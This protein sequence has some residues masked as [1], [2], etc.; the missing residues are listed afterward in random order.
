MSRLSIR[1]YLVT[2]KRYLRQAIQDKGTASFVIGNE[3]ADLDSITCALVY[4]YIQSSSPQARRKNHVVIP[5]TN[6]PAADL[7]LR[8]ELTALLRHAGVKPDDLITLDDLGKLPMP[9]S[10]IDWTLVDHNALTGCLAQHYAPSVS[11]VID[12]HD[13]ESAVPSSAS[14]RII[15]KSGSCNSLVV[16]QLRSSWDDISSNSTSVG[17][18]N[19]Q[20]SDGVID[21]EAHT[22]TWDAQVAE[23]ALGSILIDTHC[24]GDESKVTEHDRKAVRYL[25]A[26]INA[27]NKYGKDYDRKVFFEEIN[28]A[29]SDLDALSLIDVLRKDYK[30]WTEGAK[31]VGVS[32]VVKP[33]SWLREKVE[34]NFTQTLID[35]AG[36]R[37]LQLLAIMT[38]F[39]SES[40]DFA[41]ELLLIALDSEGATKAAERFVE[42]AAS[43]LKIKQ[44]ELQSLSEKG[45]PPFMQLWHQ[46]NVAA[47][48]KKV[49]P[50]LREAMRTTLA[51]N[52]TPLS[53][54]I[55][56]RHKG[57]AFR[58]A[59]QPLRPLSLTIM[60][61]TPG[62]QGG[63]QQS[64]Q[65]WAYNDGRTSV[66][67]HHQQTTF[68]QSAVSTPAPIPSPYQILPPVAMPQM[69][70]AP[71]I[72]QQHQNLHSA[73]MQ[74]AAQIHASAA[75]GMFQS[76][77]HTLPAPTMLF[78]QQAHM[79]PPAQGI[80]PQAQIG[81]APSTPV[82]QVLSP[83]SP[84]AQMAAPYSSSQQRGVAQTQRLAGHEPGFVEEGEA[85][86]SGEE[87]SEDE[88]EEQSAQATQRAMEEQLRRIEDQ[89][90]SER[91]EREV[92]TTRERK[93][94]ET[95]DAQ[96]AKDRQDREAE[97]TRDRQTREAR[98]RE[99]RNR[100]DLEVA[101]LQS[102]LNAERE[103]KDR[104]LAMVQSTL[105][106]EREKKDL[107]LAMMQSKLDTERQEKL[108]QER[109]YSRQLAAFA[110]KASSPQPQP[111]YNIDLSPL[112]TVLAELSA[113]RLQTCDIA[114]L[115]ENTM[116]R[117]LQGVARSEDLAS[118]TSKVQKALNK[119]PAN[120][121]AAD[122]QKAVEKGIADVMK[123]A[124]KSRGRG[125]QAAIE[126]G[127]VPQSGSGQQQGGLSRLQ[128]EY[129]IEDITDDQPHNSTLEAS[130]RRALPAPEYPAY[131]QSATPVMSF[132]NSRPPPAPEYPA[133]PQSAAPLASSSKSQASADRA[134]VYGGNDNELARAQLMGAPSR[135]SPPL[136]EHALS[137]S[138]QSEAGSLGGKTRKP[139][140][141]NDGN[142]LAKVKRRCAAPSIAPSA[143]TENALAKFSPTEAGPSMSGL[144]NTR[145]P[146]RPRDHEAMSQVGGV[147][148]DPPP[149]TEMADSSQLSLRGGTRQVSTGPELPDDFPDNA[150][151]ITTYERARDTRATS[152]R[153]GTTDD[154]SVDRLKLKHDRQEDMALV[155]G[156]KK[157]SKK[158][159]KR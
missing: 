149:Y 134:L 103:Q 111:T 18:A 11:G 110:E 25:E 32:S 38:A 151:M 50:L 5:V 6:I 119:L 40:G 26:R 117:Q 109:K 44:S 84:Q 36:Q 91:K 7:S 116:A 34:G 70:P 96:A 75:Q 21:D 156:S 37:Q 82:P 48:R 90:A 33:I 138:E 121:S 133:Y 61:N 81:Y 66:Q 62:G 47:S 85:S 127:P 98:D 39:T 146:A 2:A 46:K 148:V 69:L 92:Q 143:L 65:Q 77:Q 56:S 14:P 131:A 135:D 118:S 141:S 122:V 63:Y 49:G 144:S 136:A 30:Q 27:S 35:F 129:T 120:A 147:D 54:S 108:D 24:L 29:K 43:E 142:A 12:H 57:R 19:A 130:Q 99:E 94:R 124:S 125:Q 154:R 150:S 16:N 115:V 152:A 10:K 73:A 114:A 72:F 86:S 155:K 128:V 60:S 93:D 78:Q 76:M 45:R 31:T 51:T 139:A 102:R 97:D 95:R 13:D 113:N 23:L 89:H 71:N 157:E 159:W 4:G 140:R 112:Q 132:S 158:F 17:A 153:S 137:L 145:S 74:Q 106:A 59:E 42:Q 80:Y 107:E 79:L 28:A 58:S 64:N 8:P 68:A 67:Y 123:K 104:D 101:S 15:E 3:S 22:T 52:S 9:L 20:S 126:A 1:T 88:A 105:N 53:H 41:R 87:S 55:S 83:V 100:K